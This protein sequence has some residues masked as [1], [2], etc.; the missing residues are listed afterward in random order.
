MMLMKIF[1][2]LCVTVPKMNKIGKLLLT[3][4]EFFNSIALNFNDTLTNIDSIK[5]KAINIVIRK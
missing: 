2:N 1:N 3:I 5:H 4:L